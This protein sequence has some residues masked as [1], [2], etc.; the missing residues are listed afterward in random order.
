MTRG[1]LIINMFVIIPT[2]DEDGRVNEDVLKSKD[3]MVTLLRRSSLTQYEARAIT[4]GFL[5]SN[6]LKRREVNA[7]WVP[8]TEYL[9]DGYLDL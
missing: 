7:R 5:E 9:F 4:L 1:T 2:L 6:Q 3:K 8:N